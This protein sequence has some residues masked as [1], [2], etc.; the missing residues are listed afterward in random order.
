VNYLVPVDA[1]FVADRDVQYEAVALDQVM[2]ATEGAKKL[3]LV[4]LDACRD[5]R[6]RFAHPLV[7]SMTGGCKADLGPTG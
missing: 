4:I 7:R 6:K 1:K 2:A 5:N 3:H